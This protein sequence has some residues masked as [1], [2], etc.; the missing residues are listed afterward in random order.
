MEPLDL[1]G[2]VNVTQVI[3]SIEPYLVT[4]GYRGVICG[5]DPICCESN[6]WMENARVENLTRGPD[7]PFY[8]VFLDLV[9]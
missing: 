1:A 3:Y 8:Q 5:M 2:L 7:Q 9:T 4:S 6:S